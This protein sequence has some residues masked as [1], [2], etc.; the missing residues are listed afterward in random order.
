MPEPR[1]YQISDGDLLLT[2]TEDEDGWYCIT[3]PMIPGLVTQAKT[4]A[5]GFSMARE[6]RD[7]LFELRRELYGRPADTKQA[8]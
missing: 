7:E 1:S 4:I 8:S 3:A 6:V 5:E 2:F